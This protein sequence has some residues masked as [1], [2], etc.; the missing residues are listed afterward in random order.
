MGR[1]RSASSPIKSTTDSLVASASSLIDPIQ[2]RG[3]A[4][5][6]VQFMLLQASTGLQDLEVQH[7]F[8]IDSA[9]S[10]HER[11]CAEIDGRWEALKDR[12]KSRID[13]LGRI[14]SRMEAEDAAEEVEAESSKRPILKRLRKRE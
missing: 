2:D 10:R 11:E 8:E 7:S 3:V 6:F 5:S 12:L 14:R 1:S 9:E 4:L 13:Q